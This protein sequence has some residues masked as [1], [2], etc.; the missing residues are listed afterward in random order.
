MFEALG[1]RKHL[2]PKKVKTFFV[3]TIELNFNLALALVSFRYLLNAETICEAMATTLCRGIQVL[4]QRHLCSHKLFL[5]K[6]KK[7]SLQTLI[8]RQKAKIYCIAHIEEQEPYGYSKNII[9]GCYSPC[10]PLYNPL[11]NPQRRSSC[12]IRDT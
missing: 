11:K 4:F 2:L 6:A 9:C 3:F 12:Y 1:K 8:L 10:P 5:L 7:K